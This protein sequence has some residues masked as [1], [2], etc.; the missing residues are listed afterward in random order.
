M[1]LGAIAA[2]FFLFGSGKTYKSTASLW[3]DT[4]PSVPSSIGPNLGSSL[5]EPPA[6]AEQAILGE[7]LMTRAFTASVAETALHS[8]SANATG[9][10]ATQLREGG[11][12]VSTVPGGQVLQISYSSPSPA[13]AQSI[14]GAVITQLRNYTDGLTAQ[15]NEAT[16]AYDREQVKAAQASLAAARSSAATYQAQHPQA[17]SA[18]DPN[19]A[20]LVTAETNAATQ[21]AQ[22]TAALSQAGGNQNWLIQVTDPPSPATTAPLRKTKMAEVILGGLLGGLLVS[23]LAVVAL[24]PAKRE[25]WEDELPL[26]GPLPSDPFRGG[27]PGPAS[28]PAQSSPAAAAPQQR[29]LSLGDR[30]FAVKLDGARDGVPSEGDERFQFLTPSAPNDQR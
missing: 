19:Y 17:A 1:I 4:P 28:S 5:A 27:A 2:A 8:K 12:I 16:L 20:S 22:A 7:L 26:G 23:F 29:R 21:L 30:R 13:M 11:Q 24:T 14:L 18:T 10:T 3:V 9:E 25:L 6:A 15:H